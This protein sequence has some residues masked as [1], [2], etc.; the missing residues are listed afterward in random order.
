MK[1][2][3]VN[4]LPD[5]LRPILRPIYNSAR[6]LVDRRDN[7][8]LSMVPPQSMVDRYAGSGGD[9]VLI[10][11]EFKKNLV[12]LGHLR[13]S[14]MVLDVGCGI[15][16]IAVAL[17]GY[18]S[19][20]G[21][22]WG[23]DIV[24]TPI[25][26]CQSEITPRFPNFHFEHVDLY[27]KSTNPQGRIRAADFK[28]P[29]QDGFFDFVLLTSV[30]THMLPPDLE[31]YLREIARVLRAGGTCF[32]TFFLMNEESREL[33]RSGR[34]SLD[35]RHQMQGFFTT[36]PKVPENAI[37]YDD[38]LIRGLFPTCGLD[39]IHPIYYGYWCKRAT[40]LTYQ[41]VVIARKPASS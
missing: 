5:G 36:D 31:H 15:G 7:A 34:S 11:A 19:G 28:F 26:W 3:L 10:G 40:S 14:D 12:E 24:K 21:G 16:R 2:R 23:F 22:Y 25:H 1:R 9:F 20:S 37:A 8:Q 32:G 6:D 41:D 29:Y 30:F 33:V 4:L 35:F 39:I 17:T 38:D 27:N 13:P 18:L